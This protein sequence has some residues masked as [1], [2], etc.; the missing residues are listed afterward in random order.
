MH[1]DYKIR[2]LD[3]DDSNPKGG[4]ILCK[5]CSCVRQMPIGLFEITEL[6]ANVIFELGMSTAIN[7]LN[8]LLIYREKVPTGLV[9]FPPKPLELVEYIDYKLGRN[10]I[11]NAIKQ[12]IIPTIE[13]AKE[14]TK[15]SICWALRM[16]CPSS[17]TAIVPNQ[18]F[19]GLP[20][21]KNPDFFVEVQKEIEKQIDTKT[22][23]VAVFHPSKTLSELCQMCD[24]I[25]KSEFCIIDTTYNDLSMLFALGVAFGKDKR[26]I[27]LH[28]TQLNPSSGRPISDLRPWAIEYSNVAGLQSPLKDELSKRLDG[29]KNG[30]RQVSS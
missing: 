10:A 16:Q 9:D 12:K 6:N 7:N 24:A 29:S 20:F 22:Y 15:I 18:I 11:T 28:N 3:V 1:Q 8:F 27:Q 14:N 26:F 2:C 5:I 4:K 30:T 21:D 19:V 25:K 17:I 23:T 13:Q